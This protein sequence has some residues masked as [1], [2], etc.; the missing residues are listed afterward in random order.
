MRQQHELQ[1]PKEPQALAELAKPC[2]ARPSGAIRIAPDADAPGADEHTLRLSLGISR[3]N[4]PVPVTPSILVD[5]SYMQAV[6]SVA[7]RIRARRRSLTL[8]AACAFLCGTL[9]VPLASELVRRMAAPV[10][11]THVV[12]N[13]GASSRTPSMPMSASPE[14]APPHRTRMDQRDAAK[15]VHHAQELRKA[16]RVRD[17]RRLLLEVLKDRPGH[18]PGLA[19]MAELELERGQAVVAVRWARFAVRAL[20]RSVENWELLGRA[21]AVAGLH[22]ESARAHARATQLS[23]QQQ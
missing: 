21:C 23:T 5:A 2:E 10:S 14:A 16:G 11:A 8:A 22:A 12:K 18:P 13:V 9:S 4:A 7:A 15:H 19:A 1:Q 17:A 20:P 3:R 6:S